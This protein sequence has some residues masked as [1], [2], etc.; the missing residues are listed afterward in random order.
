V[1]VRDG[2][3]GQLEGRD[4]SLHGRLPRDAH[5]S[6]AAGGNAA[7]FNSMYALDTG[8]VMRSV[9][10]KLSVRDNIKAQYKLMQLLSEGMAGMCH[11]KDLAVA[12]RCWTLN[13]PKIPSR[14]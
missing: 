3:A 14:R 8:G 11:A 9:N 13:Y 6:A 2:A 10:P 12:V 4:G 1:V 7:L 5:P